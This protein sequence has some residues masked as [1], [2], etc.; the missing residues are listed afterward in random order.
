MLVGGTCKLYE[1]WV[2]MAQGN[3]AGEILETQQFNTISEII[4][5][6]NYVFFISSINIRDNYCK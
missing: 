3:K 4:N 5:I 2:Y 1:G 6:N